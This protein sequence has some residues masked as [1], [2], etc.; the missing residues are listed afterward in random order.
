[1]KHLK[2]VKS[3]KFIRENITELIIE[4]NWENVFTHC[5]LKNKL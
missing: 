1:M 2:V 5:L 3:K 4:N